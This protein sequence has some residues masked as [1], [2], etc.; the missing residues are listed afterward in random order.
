MNNETHHG[1]LALLQIFQA[2]VRGVC[3]LVQLQKIGYVNCHS[4]AH[5]LASN[6]VSCLLERASLFLSSSQLLPQASGPAL[7]LGKL[8]LLLCCLLGHVLFCGSLQLYLSCKICF[9]NVT[10]SPRCVSIS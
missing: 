2:S 1:T 5:Q 4:P 6:I 3:S 8:H 7:C 10:S 9:T